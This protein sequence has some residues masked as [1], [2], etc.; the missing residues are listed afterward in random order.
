MKLFYFYNTDFA[1][2]LDMFLSSMRDDWEHC[3][4][5]TENFVGNQVAGGRSGDLWRKRLLDYAFK[6]TAADELFVMCDIDIFFYKQLIP[7]VVAEFN[8][9]QKIKHANGAITLQP[10]DIVFQ[11]ETRIHGCNMG[12]MAMKNN[13]RVRNFWADVYDR[14][15]PRALWDQP[16]MNDVLY[17]NVVE[18]TDE[19]SQYRDESKIIWHTF[20]VHVWNWS[21]RVMPPHIAPDR[22]II[23][24][25]ANCAVSI[26]DKFAQID[27]V[28]RELTANLEDPRI[29]LKTLA[30]QTA[31]DVL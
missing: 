7:V 31:Q 8:T 2:V 11:K 20:N 5:E 16:V 23:L 25:H 26:K 12:V 1:A 29:A 14:A 4:V 30:P 24:H 6:K 9:P 22:Q 15:L 10:L 17:E 27:A 28:Y 18:K 19:Q 13:A 3:P 21:L